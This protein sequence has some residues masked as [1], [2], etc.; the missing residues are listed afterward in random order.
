MEFFNS[1]C[2]YRAAAFDIYVDVYIYIYIF[3]HLERVS[4][5]I[6]AASFHL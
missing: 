6:F 4:I 3:V 2:D 5:Y 1:L